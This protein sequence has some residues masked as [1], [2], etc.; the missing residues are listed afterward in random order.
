MNQAS[1][2]PIIETKDLC[3]HFGPTVALDHVNVKIMPGKIT[4]LIGEN[5][6]GKSTIS[7]IM[8]GMQPATSGELLL[9]G[10]SYKPASMI[11]GA[12]HGIGMIVQ[13]AGTVPGLTIAQNIFLGSE[14]AFSRFG[15]VNH[16]AMNKAAQQALDRIGFTRAKA[17]DMIDI[18]DQQERKLV[19][20]AK[21]MYRNPEILVVD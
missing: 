5:G 15:L 17:E 21:V 20:V 14:K 12:V 11:D 10:E 8:A 6:S 13:E 9:H 16:K 1:I 7:S 3:K 2:V 19:E 18:L 4:G